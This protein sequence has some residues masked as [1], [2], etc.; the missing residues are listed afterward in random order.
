MKITELKV[1]A[2]GAWNQLSLEDF[3]GEL[4]VVYGPNE[5]GKTTLMQFIRAVLYGF[6]PER[7][8]RYL[9]PVRGGTGGGSLTLASANSTLA[10]TRAED[11]SEEDSLGR[12]TLRDGEGNPQ[13]EHALTD[14]LG[15][16]DEGIFNNVFALGLSELQELN[17][18][19][20]DQVGQRLYGLA[21]GLDR[22]SL[23]DVEQ[24]LRRSQERLYAQQ[25]ERSQIDKLLRRREQLHR[26][27]QELDSLRMRYART[28]R[29]REQ[30]DDELAEEEKQIGELKQKLRLLDAATGVREFWKQR[31]EL[32]QLLEESGPEVA[33]PEDASGELERI[34]AALV[35]RG[36]R[37]EQRKEQRRKLRDE[38]GQLELNESMLQQAL[39]IEGLETQ[40]SRLASLQSR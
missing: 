26:E 23:V 35:K 2:F 22:V 40:Q 5:A 9:P 17:T 33:L 11:P 30:L 3:S 18:L 21:A 34:N 7:R 32:D 38:I 19:T 29:D 1:D 4:N 25:G 27:I 15:S 12:L 13:G 31:D 16:L 37:L 14:A 10:V 36:E 8:A 39:R 20:D 6:S 28:V 24:E